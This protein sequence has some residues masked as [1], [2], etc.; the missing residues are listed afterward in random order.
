MARTGGSSIVTEAEFP[1]ADRPRIG[2]VL[3]NWNRW[4]DTLEALE[5]LLRSDVPVTA[6]VVDNASSDGSP[7]H[8]VAWAAGQTAAPLASPDMARFSVPPLP[9]PLACRRITAAEWPTASLAPDDRLV[10]VDSGGN[11]GFAGGNNVGLKLLLADPRI[12]IFWLLNNDTVV[13]P[14]TARQ[15]AARIDATGAGMCGTVV[16][17]YWK[18][19]TVQAANG[20]M[21][22][23]LKGTA[24]GIHQ[25]LPAASLPD[26]AEVEARTSFI[27]GA[28]LAVTRPF[29]ERV[30][31]MEDSYFLYFEEIDWAA[32]NAKLPG[33]GFRVAYAPEAVVYHKEGGSIGSS[34]VPGARSLTADYW[35]AKSRLAYFRRHQ[36][37]WLPWHWG[38]TLGLAGLRV[39]R[40]QPDKAKVILKALFGG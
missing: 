36:P 19:D 10:L 2:V 6:I 21:F 32:R 20:H 29:L 26:P 15:L 11:L 33:G 12:D 16:R 8:I 30:G 17:Y 1:Q 24:R 39:V 18:P 28:S 27:L 25:G 3:V 13:A 40:G 4:A 31:L 5:S 37:A 22:S 35:L 9:K 14:D 7:D 34:G 38:V 23:T